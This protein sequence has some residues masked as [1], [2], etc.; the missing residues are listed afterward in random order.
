MAGAVDELVVAAAQMRGRKGGD[1]QRVVFRAAGKRMA[2][3]S[4]QEEMME[5][6]R[7]TSKK[8]NDS[9]PSTDLSKASGDGGHSGGKWYQ[10]ASPSQYGTI[11]IRQTNNTRIRAKKSFGWM[12]GRRSYPT[13]RVAVA[14][15][16]N[17]QAVAVAVAS[18]TGTL[19]IYTRTYDQVDGG[20]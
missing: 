16:S 14:S 11:A 1:R 19:I 13:V 12:E 15:K 18:G 17:T 2:L 6:D 4:S 3:I 9:V 20:Q 5:I 8:S 7:A 10:S